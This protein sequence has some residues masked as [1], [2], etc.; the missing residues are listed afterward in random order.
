MPHFPPF[1]NSTSSPWANPTTIA[2]TAAL[3]LED[4]VVLTHGRDHIPLGWRR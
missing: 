1:D 3:G 2:A 4:S